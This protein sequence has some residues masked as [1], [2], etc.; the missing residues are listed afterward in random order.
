MELFSSHS[1]FL[2]ALNINF[3]DICIANYLLMGLSFKALRTNQLIS[4]IIYWQYT[5]RLS[6]RFYCTFY[7]WLAFYI[8]NTEHNT[9]MEKTF[10]TIFINWKIGLECFLE[11]KVRQKKLTEHKKWSLHVLDI[12]LFLGF[13]S[14]Y[15]MKNYNWVY[16]TSYWLI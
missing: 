10:K 9:Y 6:K 8:Y 4:L 15:F 12:F 13:Y 3:S 5:K 2:L 11:Y 14:F 16:K 1:A 7:T